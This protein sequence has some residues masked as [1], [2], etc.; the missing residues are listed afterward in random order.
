[1]VLLCRYTYLIKDFNNIKR[2]FGLDKVQF[3]IE[4]FMKI[5]FSPK[6]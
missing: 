5:V 6:F 1:M 4:V 2:Y 3:K